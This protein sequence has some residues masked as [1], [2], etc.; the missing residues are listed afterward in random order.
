M[1]RFMQKAWEETD[2]IVEE[3]EKENKDAKLWWLWAKSIALLLIGTAILAI[4]A[5]PLIHSVQ[6]FS[7]SVS[8]PSF[9]VSFILVPWAT[10][11]REVA[12]AIKAARRKK[13]RT[14]SLTF[15]EVH[16]CHFFSSCSHFQ[17]SESSILRFDVIEYET[18]P[19]PGFQKFSG[20]LII[21]MDRLFFLSSYGCVQI[22]GGVFMSNI[23][24]L[25]VLLCLIYARDLT[26][27]F[28]AEVLVVLIVTAAVGAIA[29]F[30]S[31]FP[32]W[33]AILAYLLYPLS[34][35]SVYILDDLLNYS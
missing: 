19:D 5:E 27:D 1:T 26:W 35:L 12:A 13:P 29:S 30:R 23:T 34:L 15:S 16:L 17:S 4:L 18:S 7:T 25:C 21:K 10:N 28:S 24:G 32:L 22:Y 31:T 2:R 14:T 11:A 33:T 3:E 20:L 9:F 8:I 6:N